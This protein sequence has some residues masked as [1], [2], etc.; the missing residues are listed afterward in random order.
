MSYR[1]P[2]SHGANSPEAFDI[3]QPT[4]G[5]QQ[6]SDSESYVPLLRRP[7]Q[8][9]HVLLVLNAVAIR[10]HPVVDVRSLRTKYPSR[11]PASC[12]LRSRPLGD[13]LSAKRHR[14]RDW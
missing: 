8:H 4:H 10:F 12:C 7:A 9:M 6:R 1:Y 14:G 5:K 2:P 11:P 3:N 13:S